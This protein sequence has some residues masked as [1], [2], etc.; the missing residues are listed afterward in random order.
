[1]PKI[2][3]AVMVPAT[4]EPV[5]ALGVMVLVLSVKNVKPQS[6]RKHWNYK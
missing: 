5:L 2:A 4:L 3:P 1:M 6:S